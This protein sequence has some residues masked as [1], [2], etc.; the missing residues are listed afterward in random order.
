MILNCFWTP[1][2]SV[3][4]PVDV[5]IASHMIYIC[6]SRFFIINF[7]IIKNMSQTDVMN[8]Y[9][10]DMNLRNYII[11]TVSSSASISVLLEAILLVTDFASSRDFAIRLLVFLPLVVGVLEL[12]EGIISGLSRDWLRWCVAK[13]TDKVRA[14]QKPLPQISHL[15]GF[16]SAWIYLK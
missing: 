16:S 7:I 13:W 9:L 8:V 3:Q 2:L 11:T 10:Q 1:E 12:V 4:C 15:K 5:K 6:N 14:W